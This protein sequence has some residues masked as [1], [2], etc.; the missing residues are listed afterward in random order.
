MSGIA[1][2]QDMSGPTEEERL[3]KCSPEMRQWY[4]DLESYCLNLGK[5]VTKR[6]RVAYIA[7]WRDEIFAYIMFRLSRNHIAIEFRLPPGTVQ[8][9]LGFLRV[10][11]NWVKIVVASAEDVDRAKPLLKLSYQEAL[12]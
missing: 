4:R 12:R 2:E 5:D 11:G 7:F 8:P 9:E 3:R 6:L 1:K 10:E